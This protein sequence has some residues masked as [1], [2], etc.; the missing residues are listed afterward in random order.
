[1]YWFVLY[2]KFM[3][4]QCGLAKGKGRSPTFGLMQLHWAPWAGHFQPWE[5][6][7]LLALG[8]CV[9]CE[10]LEHL[11]LLSSE[12]ITNWSLLLKEL[13]LQIL[14]WLPLKWR[15][16]LIVWVSYKDWIQPCVLCCLGCW[17]LTHRP[18]TWQWCSKNFQPLLCS[19][20]HF[21]FLSGA[22]MNR[23][24]SYL[25]PK[26]VLFILHRKCHWLLIDWCCT[27]AGCTCISYWNTEYFHIEIIEI[28]HI[29][30]LH[31]VSGKEVSD[32][33]TS[34][35]IWSKAWNCLF[36][37]CL[38]P[39]GFVSVQGSDQQMWL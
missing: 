7:V 39:A 16:N 10:I 8:T 4:G 22:C 6:W 33:E 35:K 21:G 12:E 2:L 11:A 34:A 18:L 38:D 28:F 15:M 32:T 24:N 14:T 19:Q 36:S 3:E 30:F 9:S 26:P 20:L 5:V 1:M 13:E 29:S 31:P 25:V 37:F 23:H 27:S 17:S